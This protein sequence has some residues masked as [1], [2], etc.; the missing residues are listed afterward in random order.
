MKKKTGGEGPQFV[1]YF[2]PLLDALRALGDSGTPDEVV[3][4]IAQD[5]DISDEI[6]NELLPSGE[7][8]FRKNVHWARFYLAREGLLDSSKR[9]VWRLTESG[10]ATSL[11]PEQGPRTVPKVGS[12]IQR[13][14]KRQNTSA[15]AC[16][17]GNI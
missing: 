8:R 14:T 9:G 11:S 1:R 12:H 17:G 3:E 2:G 15:I 7:S 13:T 10:R 16:G 4:R 6:Q 5:Q